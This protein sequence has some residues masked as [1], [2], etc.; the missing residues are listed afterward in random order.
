MRRKTSAQKIAEGNPGKRPIPDEIEIEP[1]SKRPPL[2]INKSAR[3]YWR[4]YSPI[5]VK[6]GKLTVLNE[7]SFKKLCV[8]WAKIDAIN[9]ILDSQFKSLLQE[10]NRFGETVLTEHEYSKMLRLYVGISRQY[11]KDFG[12]TPDKMGGSYKLKNDDEFFGE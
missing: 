9:K 5:L 3:E 12:L 8:L 4:K 10:S 6:M 7:Q 1:G 2:E 11:E